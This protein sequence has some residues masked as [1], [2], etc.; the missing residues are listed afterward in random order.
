MASAAT[1]IDPDPEDFLWARYWNGKTW[2][3][4]VGASDGRLLVETKKKKVGIYRSATGMYWL[5]GAPV[6][7]PY[8]V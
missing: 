6:H 5:E 1:L 7:N 2:S 4:A 3:R 8:C